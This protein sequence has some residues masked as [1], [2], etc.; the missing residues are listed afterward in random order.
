MY[1]YAD[2]KLNKTRVEEDLQGK[3]ILQ[4]SGSKYHAWFFWNLYGCYIVISGFRV[5]Q[6]PGKSE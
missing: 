5:E 1:L 4:E 3:R 2:S 6:Y